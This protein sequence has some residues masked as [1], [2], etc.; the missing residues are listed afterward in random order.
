MSKFRYVKFDETIHFSDQ[1]K[2][3][4]GQGSKIFAIY[5]FDSEEKINYCELTFSYWLEFIGFQICFVNDI[6]DELKGD[7]ESDVRDAYA[8]DDS[9][10]YMHCHVIDNLSKDIPT[11]NE[12]ETMNDVMEQ[13][14]TNP[15][16]T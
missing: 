10:K 16:E 9:S 2:S 12:L 11:N 7:V 15:W 5:A 6:S 4:I 8:L 13:F 1:I 14:H 3:K